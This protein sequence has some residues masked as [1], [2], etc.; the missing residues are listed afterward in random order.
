M[1]VVGYA[2]GRFWV[3]GLRIDAAHHFGGLRLNQWMALIVG[4]LAALYLIVDWARHRHQP[5]TPPAPAP[6]EPDPE[7]LELDLP[8]SLD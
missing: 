6:A 1:Y 7:V 8:E 3:E 2:V 5:A 4:G